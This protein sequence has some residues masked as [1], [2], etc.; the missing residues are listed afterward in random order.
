[1]DKW[2]DSPWFIRAIALVLAILLFTSVNNELSGSNRD[3]GFAQNSDQETVQDVP[4]EIYYDTSNLVVYGAP[5]TVD[6]TISGPKSIVQ[7]T[8]AVRDFSVYLDLRNA[9]IGTQRVK[10]K[11]KDLSTKLNAKINPAY[12]DVSV[13]EKVS[14]NY[15]VDPEFNQHLLAD[16]YEAKTPT[17]DPQT[18]TITGGKD[19]ISQISYVKAS[20]DLDG[21]IN[22]SFTRDAEVQV[23]DKNLN[24]LDVNVEP[25]TVQI[26]VPVDNPSKTVPITVNPVGQESSNIAIKSITTTP[27]S[28]KIYGR[29]DVLKDIDALPVNV[30]ISKITKSQDISVPLSPPD[31]VNKLS[32]GTV[33][34]HVETEDKTEQKT[35]SNLSIDTE[36]L[37]ST[38]TVQF[39]TPPNGKVDLTASGKSGD[40]QNL[41]SSDFQVFVDLSG[42]DPG[43]HTVNVEVKGPNK[44]DWKVSTQSVKV[45]LKGNQQSSNT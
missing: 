38:D 20:I 7:N 36:G 27:K 41:S 37:P 30:D 42:L 35:F 23:L 33:T 29:S 18:V 40:M 31:G 17:I 16:G 45:T 25:D 28:V 2:M 44:V 34:V 15:K 12:V 43:D 6:V 22:S 9:K 10:L 8:K 13:Q 1:M 19:V 39:I 3:I 11:T 24:K 14:V 5:K 21:E 32:E 26:T 4:V